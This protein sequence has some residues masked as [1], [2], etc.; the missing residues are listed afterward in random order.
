[1]TQKKPVKIGVMGVTF[2]TGL[3][4]KLLLD[5]HNQEAL[6]GKLGSWFEDEFEKYLEEIAEEMML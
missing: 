5:N 6:S 1:M 3:W 2:V 4:R